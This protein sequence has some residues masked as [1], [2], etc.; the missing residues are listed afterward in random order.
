MQVNDEQL[1]LDIFARRDQVRVRIAG[2]DSNISN[3]VKIDENS[4][5]EILVRHGF[6]LQALRLETSETADTAFNTNAQSGNGQSG[7]GQTSVSNGENRHQQPDGFS[8]P[9]GQAHNEPAK[10][11]AVSAG[12]DTHGSA[13]G[14]R[15]DDIYL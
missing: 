8:R 10:R 3:G 5:K 1:L 7:N 9:G 13:G 11:H 14:R 12:R 6:N 2:L 4:I 15:S